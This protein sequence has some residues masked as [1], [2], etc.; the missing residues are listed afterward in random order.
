MKATVKGFCLLLALLILIPLSACSDPGED[1]G[2]TE[3]SVPATEADTADS[4]DMLDILFG[5]RLY[6]LAMY[7]DL[8]F[9]ELPKTAMLA[10]DNNFMSGYTK[11]AKNF[12]KKIERM[13]KSLK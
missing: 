9:E 10:T 6:D 7:F 12:D 11:S 5:N 8:G 4:A 1:T 3:T 2:E 13:L